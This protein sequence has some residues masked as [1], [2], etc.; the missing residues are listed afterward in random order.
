MR[1]LL[2]KNYHL[3]ATKNRFNGVQMKKSGWYAFNNIIVRGVKET[4]I[5]YICKKLS[6]KK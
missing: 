2:E 3:F 1:N 6:A 4:E 5:I